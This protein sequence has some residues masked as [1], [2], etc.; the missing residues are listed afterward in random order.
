[1]NRHWQCQCE[2]NF[3]NQCEPE[4]LNQSTEKF[5]LVQLILNQ[6]QR[7]PK[8]VPAFRSATL[9]HYHRRPNR[10]NWN[11]LFQ[12]F[13]INH[14]AVPLEIFLNNHWHIALISQQL[15]GCFVCSF[16]WEKRLATSVS[17][18]RVP[19]NK[20]YSV[21]ENPALAHSITLSNNLIV[22]QCE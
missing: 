11:T 15:Y 16:F 13:E 10:N 6:K 19:R 18:N 12:L 9:G 4:I 7:E 17:V 2:R 21:F 8:T 14:Y 22:W 5:N 20:N 1:M 3:L